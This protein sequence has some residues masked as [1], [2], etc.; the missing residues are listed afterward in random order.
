[1]INNNTQFTLAQSFIKI[2]D[3]KFQ[4]PL[5]PAF[6]KHVACRHVD[7]PM[8]ISKNTNQQLPTNN[9]QQPMWISKDTNQQRI[10]VYDLEIGFTNPISRS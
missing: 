8:W 9:Y 5:A 7:F 3:N 2:F 4:P 1:M 10:W 6:P